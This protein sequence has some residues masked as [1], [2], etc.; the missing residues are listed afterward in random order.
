MCYFFHYEDYVKKKNFLAVRYSEEGSI[1][2]S[3]SR[4]FFMV[5]MDKCGY[6]TVLHDF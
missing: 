3:V 2:K 1:C 4:M 6:V 5:L